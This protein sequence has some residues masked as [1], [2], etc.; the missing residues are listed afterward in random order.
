ML[1]NRF[2]LFVFVLFTQLVA[3]QIQGKVID[4]DTGEPIANV[5]IQ[6]VDHKKWAITDTQGDFEWITEKEIVELSFSHVSYIDFKKDIVVDLN[7]EVLITIEKKTLRIDEVLLIGKKKKF[8][9]IKLE[10]EAIQNVQAFTLKNVL[11]QLPGQNIVNSDFSGF[12]NVVFRTGQQ[13][14]N[15]TTHKEAFANKAFGTAIIVDDIPLSND[16]NMQSWA[17][18]TAPVF[19]NSFSVFGVNNPNVGIDLRQ[20]STET[21]D[22]IEVVQGIPDVKY[23]NLTSGLV[24]IKTKAGRTPYLASVSF[25]E[26][27]VQT[28]I[29]KGFNITDRWGDVNLS[30][31]YLRSDNDPRNSLNAFNRFNVGAIWSLYR[32]Q[33]KNTVQVS[34]FTNVDDAEENPDDVNGTTLDN[35][36]NGIRLSNNFDYQFRDNKWVD[37]FS[38]NISFSYQNQYTKRTSLVNNGGSVVPLG[39]ETGVFRAAYS[40]VAYRSTR[41]IEGKPIH[42]FLDVDIKKTVET[43]SLWKHSLKLGGSINYTDNLGA[44]QLGSP[45]TADINFIVRSNRSG[46]GVRP[47]NYKDNVRAQVNSAIYIQ[48]RIKKQWEDHFLTI[49]LGTR[50]DIQN[51]YVSWLPRLNT[52]WRYNKMRWRGGIGF[53]SKA[54]SLNQIYTGRQYYDRLV[55]DY[56]LPGEYAVAWVQT[57]VKEPQNR[58][59]K[60]TKSFK[61]EIGFDYELPIAT[62]TITGFYNRLYDGITNTDI[63]NKELLLETEVIF[64]DPEEPQLVFT[65]NTTDFYYTDSR[66]INDLS[67]V[68]KGIEFSIDFKEIEALG[69]DISVNGQYIQTSTTYG[70]SFQLIRSSELTSEEIY[71]VYNRIDNSSEIFKVGSIWKYHFAKAGLLLTLQTEHYLKDDYQTADDNNYPVAFYDANLQYQEIPEADRSNP[72]LYGHLFRGV[73]GN[74]TIGSIQNTYHNFHLRVSKDFLSGLRFDFYVNNVFNL[75]PTYTDQDNE[76]RQISNVTGLSFGSKLTY[77]F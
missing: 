67:S 18:N 1:R 46:V 4:K 48:D 68:D 56:R 28:S 17:T 35:H 6:D 65:G 63:I 62:A 77:K 11:S 12:E 74:G 37:Q 61:T 51:G 76:I 5:L 69:L 71:G 21:I 49:Q 55:G 66:I 45:E 54:P 53:A 29:S 70:D 43:S 58:D 50:V 52:S 25:R 8:S 24:K 31:S 7:K 3:S 32:E 44:G 20:I 40:P 75:K 16:A 27:T 42:G 57:Y 59:L 10:T 33:F 23:G 41:E 19:G 34:V 9:E 38:A 2:V 64:N 22:E 39:L 30:A 14:G 47:Y 15:S 36:T 13:I 72:A 26:G 73:T 60:P